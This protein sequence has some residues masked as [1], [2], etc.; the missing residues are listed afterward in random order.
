MLALDSVTRSGV[1]THKVHFLRYITQTARFGSR[2]AF[3]G[4]GEGTVKNRFQA[5]PDGPLTLALSRETGTRVRRN[6]CSS[7]GS[8]NEGSEIIMAGVNK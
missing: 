6:W 2:N 7:D 5:K 8:G 3:Q 1:V 4:D